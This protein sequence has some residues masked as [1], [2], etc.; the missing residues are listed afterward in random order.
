LEPNGLPKSPSQR[1]RPDQ[2]LRHTSDFQRVFQQRCSVSDELLIVYARRNSLSRGRLGLSVSRR[3]GKAHVRNRWKRLIREVYRRNAQAAA[4][5]D[6]IV[7]PRAVPVGDYHSIAISLTRLT[8]RLQQK[9]R[10]SS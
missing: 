6:L 5:L 9:L 4:G 10:A 1:L 3:V 7:I 8:E 2:R